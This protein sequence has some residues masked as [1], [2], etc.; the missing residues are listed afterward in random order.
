[1]V[2]ASDLPGVGLLLQHLVDDVAVTSDGDGE[3]LEL[4]IAES[5]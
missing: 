3:T 4:R 2:D 5:S 1:V